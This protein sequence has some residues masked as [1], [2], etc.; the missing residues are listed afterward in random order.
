MT[1]EHDGAAPD[2]LVVDAVV[3]A[4]ARFRALSEL[5]QDAVLWLRV[6]EDFEVLHVNDTATV[7]TGL[8]RAELRGGRGP[9]LDYVL[10]P[11]DRPL[12]SVP[13]PGSTE[14]TGALVRWR[15]Q[16]GSVVWVE[17]RL[18]ALGGTDTELLCVARDVTDR[19]NAGR[20]W[21]QRESQQQAVSALSRKAAT[22][23]DPRGLAGTAVECLDRIT[24]AD[25]VAVW[26]ELEPGGDF[27]LVAHSGLHGDLVQR[28][29]ADGVRS[30]AGRIRLIGGPTRIDGGDIRQGIVGR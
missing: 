28:G 20:V 16:D 12:V 6:G 27:E 23:T 11:E 24:A 18:L 30:H 3:R 9:L 26:W 17:Q 2:P 4:E 10:H 1:A 19:I 14:E 21:A 29:V 13:E 5:T 7:L 25:A 22:S 8:S 15:R